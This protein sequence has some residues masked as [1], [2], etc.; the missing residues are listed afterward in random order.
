MSFG[1]RLVALFKQEDVTAIYSQGDLSMKDIQKHAEIQGVKIVGPRHE[2]SGVFMAMGHYAMAGKPQV[3]LGAIGPGQAN[4]LP[5][6]VTAA[7]E[8]MPVILMGARRHASVDA[9]VRRGRWLYAPMMD[10]FKPVCKYTAR[11]DSLDMLDEVMQEAFRQAL[12]GTPGP[13][14]IEYDYKLNEESGN[15]PPLVHPSRYRSSPQGAPSEAISKSV[16]ML[17]KSKSI[18]LLGGEGIHHS[19]AHEKFA[20]LAEQLACPVITT[21]GGSGALPETDAKWLMYMSKAGQQAIAEADVILAVGTCFP[22]MAN[23]GRLRHFDK[24]DGDRKVIVIEKDEA[25]IGV[26]RPVDLALIGAIDK[27]LDQLTAELGIGPAF[28]PHPKLTFWR[29]EY[30]AE[31]QAMIDELPRTNKIYPGTLMVEARKAVPENAVIVVDGGLTMLYQHSCFQKMA[32]D[33]IYTANFSHLGTGLGLAI[34]AATAT[35]KKKPVCLLSGDGALGFHIMDFETAVRHALP[36][37][38]IINDDQALGAEMAQHMEH[39]GHQIEV[40]FGPVRYSDIAIAMGGLG[41]YVDK[42][43]DIEPSIREAF[44]SGRPA[45]VQVATDQEASYAYAPPYLDELV[46]WLEADP[47]NRNQVWSKSL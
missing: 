5:A 39:I 21:L 22:E 16:D 12:A 41:F 15:F 45:I 10:M 29:E 44:A 1:E 13:V 32:T 9:S 4:L 26:N 20:H 2:A 33:F 28:E 37:V 40:A 7:Q 42:V 27:V 17:R 6:A 35:D 23:Y 18:L 47:Q 14:Y 36:L 31:R 43:Q 8:H 46:S 3:A 30:V 11:L 19:R 24:N 34:G 38:V 25:A